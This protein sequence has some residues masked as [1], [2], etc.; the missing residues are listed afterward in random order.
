VYNAAVSTVA[1]TAPIVEAGYEIKKSQDKAFVIRPKFAYDI[2]RATYLTPESLILNEDA[3][4][5]EQAVLNSIFC[6]R[7]GDIDGL[8]CA[9]KGLRN[10]LDSTSDPGC[11]ALAIWRLMVDASFFG[12]GEISLHYLQRIQFE[13]VIYPELR[14]KLLDGASAIALNTMSHNQFGSLHSPAYSSLERGWRRLEWD[15][16]SPASVAGNYS[17]GQI[18]FLTTAVQHQS[19]QEIAR[20]QASADPATQTRLT[21]ARTHW[22]ESLREV[23][24]RLADVPA[25][26]AVALDF[27]LSLTRPTFHA[28]ITGD[29][30]QTRKF[31]DYYFGRGAMPPDDNPHIAEARQEIQHNWPGNSL[32]MLLLDLTHD[33]TKA[34]ER[35]SKFLD[36]TVHARNTQMKKAVHQLGRKLGFESDLLV[37][38]FGDVPLSEVPQISIF[39]PYLDA[40]SE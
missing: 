11:Q 36:S 20:L 12:E 18:G 26:R 22:V 5:G 24:N 13:R 6:Y 16:T 9:Q 40:L 31:L 19:I 35:F 38:R 34:N 7:K 32:W 14:A 1:A 21:A 23:T 33:K 17:E 39:K 27:L 8:A 3:N 4:E 2:A 37:K 28:A 29:L 15:L 10:A 30:F 25:S